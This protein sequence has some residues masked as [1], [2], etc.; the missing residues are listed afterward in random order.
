MKIIADEN[1]ADVAEYFGG[2]GELTLMPGRAINA[3]AVREADV[4][5]VRSVTHVDR[6]LLQQSPCKFVGTATSGIDHIDTQ[7]LA[8]KNIGLG[9]ARGCNA[10]SVVDYVFS[11]M[12]SL[13]EAQGFDWRHLSFGIAGCGEVGSRLAATLLG[14]QC[15]VVI[16]DP[17]LAAT[18]LLAAH[19][20]DY[21]SVLKQDVVC[22]HTPITTDG[23]WPTWHML[24]GAKLNT[25]SADTVLVNAGRGAVID[26]QALLARLEQ[27]P[28]QQ[29]V[30]D[31]WEGEPD[32]NLDLLKRANIAT[33]HIAG[34]SREGKLNGT[35]MIYAQFGEFF[36]L[37]SRHQSEK[38]EQKIR[39]EISKD[40]PPLS[41]LNQLI[42][43]AYDVMGDHARMQELLYAG[44]AGIAFDTLRKTYPLRHE[45][46]AFAVAA[47]ELSESLHQR[48]RTLGFTL[49]A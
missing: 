14:L 46:S 5:L 45:F 37:E 47:G 2:K 15:R 26:N 10:Q 24:D 39:L 12:A 11:A 25:L 17:F 31:T 27:H 30:L 28:Q 32:I 16:H 18:H 3:Q 42:K 22:F 35:R 6:Y 36:G 23:P 7:W 21:N 38:G 20:G 19:F 29:V 8:E 9:W 41:Q 4:L 44:N 43:N 40:L 1:I 33:P 34:Y 13:S 48:V 49:T